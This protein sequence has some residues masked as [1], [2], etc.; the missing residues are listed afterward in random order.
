MERIRK[1]VCSVEQASILKR[2]GVKQNSYFFF[3]ENWY[4]KDEPQIVVWDQVNIERVRGRK[5][6]H[7][8]K[9]V[10]AFMVGEISEMLPKV[11]YFNDDTVKFVLH[12]SF[13][14]GDD[15]DNYIC[16]YVLLSEDEDLSL[17]NIPTLYG[18]GKT[19]AESRADLL[20][21]LIKKGLLKEK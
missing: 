2:L 18:E 21:K 8:F 5:K 17:D 15:F 9:F 13:P 11:L 14:D 12:Q 1:Q 7:E 19:E 6:G 20:I 3:I 16:E 4:V 10:S